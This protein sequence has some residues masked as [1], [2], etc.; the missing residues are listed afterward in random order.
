MKPNSDAGMH[1]AMFFMTRT[2]GALRKTRLLTAGY[3][4]A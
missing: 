2:G 3:K 1:H 4:I